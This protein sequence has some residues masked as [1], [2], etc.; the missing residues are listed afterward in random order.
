ML[1]KLGSTAI[2]FF[3]VSV[4]PWTRIDLLPNKP[5]SIFFS[6]AQTHAIK[7]WNEWFLEMDKQLH[8]YSQ[9]VNIKL[10]H[11]MAHTRKVIIYVEWDNVWGSKNPKSLRLLTQRWL[12]KPDK[13]LTASFTTTTR[14]AHTITSQHSDKLNSAPSK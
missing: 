6:L 4:H 1:L 5:K 7:I 13:S 12:S 3:C 9:K 10:A 2:I 11:L 14:H 8:R